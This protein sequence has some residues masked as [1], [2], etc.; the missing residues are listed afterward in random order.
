MLSLPTFVVF[1]VCLSRAVPQQR[2]AGAQEFGGEQVHD[3]EHIKEHLEGK[4]DP[5]AD[6]TPEQLQFH[7]FNIYDLNKDGHLDGVELV[8]AITH[9][10]EHSE[11]QDTPNQPPP[12]LPTDDQLEQLIDTILKEND[13]NNN[14][15]I[16]YG[17]Y[18][19]GQQLRDQKSP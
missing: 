10:H 18:I 15:M 4:V 6:M 14:G 8:K 1:F 19:L 2:P 16:D 17:E 3:A 7:Y 11:Q 12:P 9:Y 13:Y 5:T